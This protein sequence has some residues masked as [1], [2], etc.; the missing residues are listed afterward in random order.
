MQNNMWRLHTID[1]ANCL[2]GEHQQRKPALLH[3]ASEH[4]KGLAK[5]SIA[6]LQ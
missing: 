6:A 5:D 1:D 3:K 2:E 4:Y